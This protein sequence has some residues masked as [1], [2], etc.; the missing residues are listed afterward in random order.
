MC[1]SSETLATVFTQTWAFACM[2]NSMSLKV[3]KLCETLPTLVTQVWTFS[4]VCQVVHQEIET[5]TKTF[6]AHVTNIQSITGSTVRS[7]SENWFEV[8][9]G[10]RREWTVCGKFQCHSSKQCEVYTLTLYEA[11]IQ[12]YYFMWQLPS[13][14]HSDHSVWQQTM[15]HLLLLQCAVSSS[16][17][18]AVQCNA[19][20]I[21]LFST[22]FKEGAVNIY[23]RLTD[24][25]KRN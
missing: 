3:T 24:T 25:W 8:W 9:A 11:E 17:H 14:C 15:L 20:G 22:I 18:V 7:I 6:V 16:P 12:E 21:T 5:V 23:C 4:C 2:Y 1:G 13:L 10:K 19:V